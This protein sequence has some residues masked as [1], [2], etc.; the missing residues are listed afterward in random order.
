M[1]VNRSQ[2]LPVFCSAVPTVVVG[3]RRFPDDGC[4]VACIGI[5]APY[6]VT[7]EERSGSTLQV[8]KES[9]TRNRRGVCGVIRVWYDTGMTATA[10]GR[11]DNDAGN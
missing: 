11:I 2:R 9:Q 10:A 4:P 3:E 5:Q 1:P 6:D 7:S 8:G